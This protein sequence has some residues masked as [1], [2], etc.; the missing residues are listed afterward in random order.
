[1]LKSVGIN[2]TVKVRLYVL[3]LLYKYTRSIFFLEQYR[4]ITI[5]EKGEWSFEK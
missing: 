5:L 4:K 3:V 2:V 1:V